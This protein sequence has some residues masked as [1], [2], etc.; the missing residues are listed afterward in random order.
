MIEEIV[1]EKFQK[2]KFAVVFDE[3]SEEILVFK[4]CFDKELGNLYMEQIV[5][6]KVQ[7]K[8]VLE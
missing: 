4:L 5:I 2:N 8:D 6:E 7:T 3:I 1:G